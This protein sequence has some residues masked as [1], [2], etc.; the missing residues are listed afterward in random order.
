MA[1]GRGR[2][3]DQGQAPLL[4]AGGRSGGEH[5]GCAG[6]KPAQQEGGQAV[7]HQIAQGL[8]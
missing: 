5:A 7:F 1:S 4:V 8:V 2:V 3:D 6:A